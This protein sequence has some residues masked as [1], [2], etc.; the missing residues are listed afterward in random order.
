VHVAQ[1]KGKPYAYLASPTVRQGA[2]AWFWPVTDG[3]ETHNERRYVV[4]THLITERLRVRVREELGATYAPSASLVQFDGFPGFG[5]LVAYLEIPPARAQEVTRLVNA[6]IRRLGSR[7]I[8]DEE[9][10]RV[11][12]PLLRAREEDLRTNSY[13]LYTVLRDV[14]QHP[15]RLAAVRDRKADFESITS[16]EI[17]ALAK[18]CLDARQCFFFTAGPPIG[19]GGTPK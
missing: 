9:F 19:S 17:Q 16:K 12:Q 4:L 13:W 14:Q 15:E 8:P 3:T 10:Q 7:R 11:K 1:S 6:E 5:Y 2:L 18:R